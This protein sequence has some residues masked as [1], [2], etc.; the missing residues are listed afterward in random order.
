MRA[1]TACRWPALR[2][3]GRV[4]VLAPTGTPLAPP[5]RRARPGG[6]QEAGGQVRQGR[7]ETR[8]ARPMR[9]QPRHGGLPCLAR[10][11]A[12]D[13]VKAWVVA[14]LINMIHWPRRVDARPAGPG[15][16]VLGRAPADARG[17]WRRLGFHGLVHGRAPELLMLGQHALVL[18]H[19]GLLQRSPS[20]GACSGTR[21]SRKRCR[22]CR[23]LRFRG[24]GRGCPTRLVGGSCSQGWTGVVISPRRSKPYLWPFATA[25]SAVAPPAGTPEPDEEPSP[26]SRSSNLPLHLSSLR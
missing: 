21:C 17:H 11:P 25:A 7:Q 24:A 1:S 16:R 14:L 20:T 6:A 9:G 26:L 13:V 19:A 12:L 8:G 22:C 2:P 18:H 10:E 3:R 23:S 15:H 4:L 5:A